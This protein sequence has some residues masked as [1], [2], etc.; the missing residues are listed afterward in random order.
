[1]HLRAFHGPILLLLALVAGSSPALGQNA[2]R[3]GAPWLRPSQFANGG[4]NGLLTLQDGSA[5]SQGEGGDKPVESASGSQNADN[6]SFM[7]RMNSRARWDLW[8]GRSVFE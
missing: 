1:M 3:V 7:G 8:D 2:P 6:D 5:A 4:L